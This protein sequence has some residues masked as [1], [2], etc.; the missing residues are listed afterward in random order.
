MRW[1]RIGVALLLVG[2]VAW[3]TRLPGEDRCLGS[4]ATPL[5]GRTENQR[6]NAIRAARAIDGTRIE[7]GREFSFNRTVGHWTPD[8]G[9]KLA[10]VSY[11]GEMVDDWGGGVCQ[12]SSALYN[13][14]LV[15]GLEIVER[16]RHTWQPAY[17]PPG[18]DAAVAQW[19]IDLRFTNPHPWAVVL[20]AHI[21]EDS[22]G[23]RIRG[24]EDGPFAV[25]ECRPVATVEPV[26]VVRVDERVEPGRHRLVNRGRVG[27]RVAVYRTLLRGA[28]AG[29]RELV[30]QD[31]YPALNRL[32]RVGERGGE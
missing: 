30:S 27:A 29:A 14:T 17:V 2:A 7:S 10:P 13:A 15:A 4:Y 24:A 1:F 26:E 18:R 16:H 3:A 11:D 22:L 21:T 8:Q 12:T 32:V 20:R 31:S 5:R 19:N 23:F 25:V 9:Y 28:R 6:H